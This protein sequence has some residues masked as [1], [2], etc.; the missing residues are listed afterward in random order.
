M[1]SKHSQYRRSPREAFTLIEVMLV[2]LILMVLAGIAVSSL[3]SMRET[4]RKKEAGI[5]V[6]AMSTPLDLFEQDHGRY[7]STAEGLNALISPPSEVDESKGTWPYVSP[8]A[9][10]PDPWGSQYQYMY[11]GQRN[12]EGARGYDLWSLGPDGIDG[13][14][15]DIGNW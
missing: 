6:N 15:D 14:A 4:A 1:L 8:K 7:P 3:R 12:P 5:F 13:N 9:V 10:K 2:L 11:P